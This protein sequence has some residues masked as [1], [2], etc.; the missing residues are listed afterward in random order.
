[1]LTTPDLV[2]TDALEYNHGYNG[3]RLWSIKMARVKSG[4]E[5]STLNIQWS[6]LSRDSQKSEV[7]EVKFIRY[8]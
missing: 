5:Q 8:E 2:R 4:F 3:G 1:M 6:T 7:Y